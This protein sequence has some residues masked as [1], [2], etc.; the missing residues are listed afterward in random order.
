M[1]LPDAD[2]A[3]RSQ[4]G[5]ELPVAIVAAN[6]GCGQTGMFAAR[7][8]VS[9]FRFSSQLFSRMNTGCSVHH[10]RLGLFLISGSINLLV[11]CANGDLVN[12]CEV[13]FM[14]LAIAAHRPFPQ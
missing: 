14:Q 6:V 3:D 5:P 9:R 11:R 10:P 12:D 1:T 8:P 13:P 7:G 2:A 4:P